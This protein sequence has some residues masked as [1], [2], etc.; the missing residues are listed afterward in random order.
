MSEITKDAQAADTQEPGAPETPKAAARQATAT[1]K[2]AYFK[3]AAGYIYPRSALDNP[4]SVLF[5]RASKEE[6][7]EFLVA[8]GKPE[9]EAKKYVASYVL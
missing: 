2:Q 1:Q 8:Q 5:G 4:D 6:V 3:D 7:C 9:A